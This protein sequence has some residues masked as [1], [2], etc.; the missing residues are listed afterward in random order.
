MSISEFIEI[1]L[2]MMVYCI[3]V[4]RVQKIGYFMSSYVYVQIAKKMLK[5][6]E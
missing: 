3:Y 5:M 2:I 1:K 4:P 6:I